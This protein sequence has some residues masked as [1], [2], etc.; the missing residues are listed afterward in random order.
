MKIIKIAVRAVLRVI[1][2]DLEYRLVDQYHFNQLKRKASE[3][4]WKAI[5]PSPE[6]RIDPGRGQIGHE[7]FVFGGFRQNGSVIQVVDIFD[8]EKEK[9][10]A[11]INLPE[12]MAQTHLGV[13][14]DE[15]RYVYLV[16]GQLGGACR[17]ATPNCFVFDAKNHFFDKLPSLP[18]PRYAPA[19]QLWR[20]RLHSVAGAK[21]DRN[22]PATDHWSIAVENG[23][24][25]EKEWREEPPIPHGGHHRAS[26]VIQDALYVFGGQEGDYVAI[27]GNPD[28][29]CTAELTAEV[30]FPDTYRLKAGAKAWDRMADMP[31]LSSHTESSVI[32]FDDFVFILGGDYERHAQKDLITINEEI[33]V[34]DVKADSWKIVGRLPYHVKAMAAGYYKGYLYITCGQRGKGPNDSTPRLK[35]ERGTWKVK[36]SV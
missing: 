18:Q 36:F 29:R 5:A 34:Y 14:S 20:D 2:S 19:V 26:A 16:S 22:T 33:Q 35:F 23:K 4:I 9:W 7:L 12:D 10:T 24:A 30:R 15:E 27:P 8:F 21:E 25:I 32:K 28:Y 11:R 31:I 6:A 3:L 17:P 13:A 1:N